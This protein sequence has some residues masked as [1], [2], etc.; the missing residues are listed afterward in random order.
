MFSIL[1]YASSVVLQRAMPVGPS[2][3]MLVH[4]EISLQL[5][6]RLPVFCTDIQGLGRMKQTD[7]VSPLTFPLA[8]T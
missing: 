1:S 8:P 2:V 3:T 6:N 4:T 5:L 7:F